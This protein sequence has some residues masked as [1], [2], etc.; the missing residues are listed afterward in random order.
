MRV[1]VHDTVGDARHNRG[2][3]VTTQVGEHL[4]RFS[5][6]IQKVDVTL[7]REGH[8]AAEVTHCHL[9]ACLGSLGVVVADSRKSDDHSALN[10]ALARLV[11]GITRRI[12]KRQAKETARV[13][14]AALV[15]VS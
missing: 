6:E 9:A 7:S 15:D 1:L 5:S 2:S 10:G 3:Y 4:E 13:A 8:H 12:E 11:R 14:L